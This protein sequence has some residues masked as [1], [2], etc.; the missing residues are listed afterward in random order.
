MGESHPPRLPKVF[1]RPESDP[2]NSSVKS[3]HEAQKVLAANMLN[4]APRASIRM[5][6][7]L[8][9][10]WLPDH[11][12]I[13]EVNIPIQTASLLP[14]LLPKGRTARLE[15]QPPTGA[16]AATPMYG[17]APPIPA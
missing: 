1:I 8:L 5:A 12:R 6:A 3:M 11:N 16:S 10:T 14:I 15:N 17:I 4:P 7:P 13:P 9:E 2:V